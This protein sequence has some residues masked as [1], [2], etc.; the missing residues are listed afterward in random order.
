MCGI[1]GALSFNSSDFIITEEYIEQ[2]R[3]TLVHRG[4][5]GA[6]VWVSDDKKIGLGHR[7]LSIIDLS[8]HASQPMSNHE[9]SLHIVFNGEIYNHADIK[10][11]LITLGYSDWKTDHS[12]TEVILYAFQEWGINCIEKFR[13]MFAIAIWDSEKKELWLI[14]DRVGIKPLY[15]SIHNGRI[16]F[17]SE[18]KALLEDPAQ[19]R[20]VNESGLFHYLSFLTVP[21]PETLFK[22]I[23]KIPPGTWLNF[24]MSG[25]KKEKRYWDVL[26]HVED[27]Q[28]HSEEEIKDGV[29]E[30]LREAVQL[31]KVSDVPVG[32][33]L[34]GGIDS[35]TNAALFSEEEKEP[36]KTFSIGYE[37]EHKSYTN[38]L[39]F[40]KI[41]SKNAGAEYYE[42][43]LNIDDLMDFLPKMIKLQDEPIADPVCMPVYY[44]SALAKDNGVTVCQVGEGADELF[45]GYPHWKKVLRAENLAER[46][47]PKIIFKLI[48]KILSFLGLDHNRRFD[49]IKRLSL[50]QPM[51]WGP[52]PYSHNEKMRLLSPRMR[53]SFSN[54]NSWESIS[55]IHERFKKK[56]KTLS[57]LDWMTYIDLHLRLSE[58]LLMRV[59]KMSMGVS[60]ETRVPF[61]DHKLVEYAFSIPTDI[62]TKDGVLK[63]ILKKSV[64]GIIPDEIIDREKQG[65]AAPVDEWFSEDLGGL[66][67]LAEK[68][69]L[70]FCQHTDYLDWETVKSYLS[71]NT[72]KELWPLLNLALWWNEYIKPVKILE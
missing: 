24:N 16:V 36:V 58:L 7:R 69:L 63:Y 5:D 64:R 30:H 35:S 67:S 38:E 68:Q 72:K 6:G 2:M 54:T 44:V 17:G 8:N 11:E 39:G 22:G 21:S 12:D 27:L 41:A 48:V 9:Q 66:G 29:L 46:Y 57:H 42:K 28:G 71:N 49:A 37:D 43:L 15:Y 23:Y 32:V 47:I 52:E 45:W 18:I 53:K 50:S 4:P 65:F 26:N 19:E 60:L 61:L 56:S 51:Y 14:R 55:N 13:G 31:R 20:E 10:K 40:A 1:V 3:E 34:S 62:K 25:E 33:F 59:D 70:D